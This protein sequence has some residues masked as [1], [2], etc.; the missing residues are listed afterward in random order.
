MNAKEMFAQ[1][2][3]RVKE[4]KK[5]IVPIATGVIGALIGTGVGLLATRDV[6][7]DLSWEPTTEEMEMGEGSGEDEPEED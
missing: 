2:L 5:V 1:F 3:A 6:G 7:P 4:N